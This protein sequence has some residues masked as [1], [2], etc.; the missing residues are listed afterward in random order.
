MYCVYC[1]TNK[2]NGKKYFGITSTSPKK[3]WA[4]GHGY[5]SSRHFNFAIQKYGWD[6][7]EHEV[8]ADNL[9][10]KQACELE[11]KYIAK[12]NTTDDRYGY[13]L[14]DGGESGSS[15]IKQSEETK[16]K[17]SAKLKGR[18]FSEEHRRKLS[19]KA[20]GR[21][22]SDETLRKMSDAKKGR[23]LSK[24]H[25]QHMSEAHKGRKMSES[26]KNKLRESKRGSMRPVYCIETD[27]TYESISAAAKS[28]GVSRSNLAATC[29]GKH[30][31]VG[32]Y[33]VRYAKLL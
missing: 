1:H 4:A 19:E 14:S 10:K 22:F 2:L 28:L 18:Q 33:H 24:E 20:K 31:H 13:N 9:T 6:G 23:K 32:G 5:R 30:K 25:R 29:K 3:R 27:T 11:R 16:A 15:G 12:F 21:T 8:I 17:K 26:A 7:F